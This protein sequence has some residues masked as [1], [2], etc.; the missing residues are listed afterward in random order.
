[1]DIKNNDEPFHERSSLNPFSNFRHY[2]IITRKKRGEKMS[3]G[4]G[5][6]LVVGLL[7]LVIII[8][9]MFGEEG[10]PIAII[11]VFG[12][13]ALIILARMG[14]LKS[15]SLQH[16]KNSPMLIIA[17]SSIEDSFEKFLKSQ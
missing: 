17:N 16:S 4:T 1:L 9:W 7:I 13:I 10:G 5:L 6:L 11:I 3:P 15:C 12:V 8:G 2:K 14:L